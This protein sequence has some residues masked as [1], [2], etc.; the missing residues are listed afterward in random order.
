MWKDVLRR[1]K[2]SQHSKDTSDSP[3]ILNPKSED[4][5]D[6]CAL[7]EEIIEQQERM[8]PEDSVPHGHG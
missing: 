1:E 4:D 5:G 8:Y 2:R 3:R 6:A 7:M